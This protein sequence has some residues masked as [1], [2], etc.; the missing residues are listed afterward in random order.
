MTKYLY[1]RWITSF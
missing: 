1:Y